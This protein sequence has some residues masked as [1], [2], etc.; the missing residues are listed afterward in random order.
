MLLKDSRTKNVILSPLSVKL[1]LTLLAEAA[2][3]NVAS[4]TRK[5]I[6]TVLFIFCT[7]L[8]KYLLG[9]RT[10]VAIQQESL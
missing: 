4:A 9:I 3:Q 5:V 2:G 6:S 7:L 10:S 8:M 1:L